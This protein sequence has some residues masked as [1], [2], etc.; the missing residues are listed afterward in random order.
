[1]EG[2]SKAGWCLL[3]CFSWA[4]QGCLQLH[5]AAAVHYTSDAAPALGVPC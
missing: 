2:P 3:A 1:M 4:T 5:A